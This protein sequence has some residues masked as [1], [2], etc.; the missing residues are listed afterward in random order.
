VS[1]VPADPP[2]PPDVLE[3]IAAADQVVIG[4]GSLFTSVLAAAVVPGIR[5]ALMATRARRIYVCNL[6]PQI[7]ETAGY[8][9]ED[10]IRA[11][12]EH[13]VHP[14]VVLTSTPERPLARSDGAA[15][16]P[17]LLAQALEDLI[18]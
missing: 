8:T 15:H 1:L 12:R 17:V 14:D 4:P 13:G 5:D 11:L 10:H 2:A 18:P 3:A 7:P 16:D 9:S 6:R